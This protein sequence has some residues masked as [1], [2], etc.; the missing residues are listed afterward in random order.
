L[1]AVLIFIK[2]WLDFHYD[3]IYVTNYQVVV[4]NRHLFGVERNR[5][6]YHVITHVHPDTKG[7]MKSI[8]RFGDVTIETATTSNEKI[9]FT[10]AHDVEKIVRIVAKH[11]RNSIYKQRKEW[12]TSGKS[13]E[14]IQ[15]ER[16]E[17]KKEKFLEDES[18]IKNKNN[19]LPQVP[20]QTQNFFQKKQQKIHQAE[21]VNVL[22]QNIK[23][24]IVK[25]FRSQ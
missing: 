24:R 15:E 6:L 23:K 7:L 20:Y 22:Q 1:L 16:G 19:F 4:Q 18:E 10:Y 9:R 17:I 13:S 11:Q 8:F 12:K 2:D 25:N 14:K 5:I 21:D 3:V